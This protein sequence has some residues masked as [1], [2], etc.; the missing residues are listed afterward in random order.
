MVFHLRKEKIMSKRVR[1]LI[2]DD[3]WRMG[4][5]ESWFS[6]MAM[7]GLH[8][9]RIGLVFATFERGEP[10]KT[11]YR[12]DIIPPIKTE[13]H[14]E[15]YKESGW[16]LVT[17]LN[18][19]YIFSS[20]EEVNY[21][22]LPTDSMEQ[23]YTLEVLNRR[24]R[25]QVISLSI[26]LTLFLGMVLLM[27][28]FQHNTPTLAMIEGSW[29]QF[30]LIMLVEIYVFYTVI[31]SFIVLRK[32]KKSL[33]EGRP[34]NHQE[35]WRK[36]RLINGF[37]TAFF[38]LV[39]FLSPCIPVAEI[40]C[41]KT[42]TLPETP[43]DLPVIRLADIEKNPA[44]ERLAGYSLRNVDRENRVSYN[45]T[46]LSPITYEIYEHGIVK[47][48]K[49]DDSSGSYSPS[50]ETHYYKLVF[51]SMANGLIHDLMERYVDYIDPNVMGQEIEHEF[52]NKLFVAEGGIRKQFFACL[53]NEVIYVNYYGNE[54]AE[55][56][57]KLLP[58][59]FMK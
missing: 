29:I 55:D 17:S 6:D 56:I 57:I 4:R 59:V 8:L 19:L 32:L 13:E 40:V 18:E 25:N 49:W 41:S 52:F 2:Q 3:I 53:G 11:K 23:S 12:M 35:S 58:N 9:R 26:L 5:N 20:P 1:R 46:P 16:Q 14:F 48:I 15:T 38:I 51:S 34:I 31:R 21:P 45:W 33:S 42:Y 37:I 44:L 39:A 27:L 28:F 50:I 43:V 47:N 54:Q 24:M 22:E 30:P 7:K 10:K 36:P